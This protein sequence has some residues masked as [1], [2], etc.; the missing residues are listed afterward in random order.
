[1]QVGIQA[2]R[3]IGSV[4]V[5]PENRLS[6]TPSGYYVVKSSRCIDAGSARQ[7]I[8]ISPT[9]KLMYVPHFSFPPDIFLSFFEKYPLTSIEI[10]DRQ[11]QL[12]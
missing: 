5:I 11:F 10:F 7:E 1:M 12:G 6:F 3:E 4:M 2:L 9:Y 8:P